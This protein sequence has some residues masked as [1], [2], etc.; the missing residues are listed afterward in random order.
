MFL[1]LFLA[2]VFNK[3]SKLNLKLNFNFWQTAKRCKLKFDFNWFDC[4]E[5]GMEWIG[6]DWSFRNCF[7]WFEFSAAKRGNVTRFSIQS[8]LFRTANGN[9]RVLVWF[10]LMLNEKKRNLIWFCW[11][12]WGLMRGVIF[13]FWNVTNCN[14]ESNLFRRRIA[15]SPLFIW[16]KL[17]FEWLYGIFSL[18]SNSNWIATKFRESQVAV[19]FTRIFCTV[20]NM[21]FW[22]FEKKEKKK[23]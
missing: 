8:M 14:C 16:W 20:F 13:A 22:A 11:F 2:G 1:F 6:F 9:V 7:W 12:Y 18:F 23:K 4:Y 10:H 5:G 17:D 21:T 3:I 19:F 15:F